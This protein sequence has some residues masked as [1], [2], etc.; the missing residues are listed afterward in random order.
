[1]HNAIEGIGVCYIPL[2][3]LEILDLLRCKAMQT[4]SIMTTIEEAMDMNESVPL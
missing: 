4:L 2:A 1:M 3:Y